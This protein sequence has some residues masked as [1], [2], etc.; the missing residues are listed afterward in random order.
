M[1]AAAAW[2][3]GGIRTMQW[4]GVVA[5]LAGLVYLV[6]PGL[7]APP[8]F[9]A[10]LLGD[11]RFLVGHLFAARTCGLANPLAQTTTNFTRATPMVLVISLVAY[12]RV[13]RASRNRVRDCVGRRGIGLGLSRGA[14]RFAASPPRARLSYNCQFRCSPQQVGSCS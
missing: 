6:S 12:R 1:L 8:L 4:L 14:R 11:G 3:L 2:L 10:T 13:C 9:A 5:A 7:T